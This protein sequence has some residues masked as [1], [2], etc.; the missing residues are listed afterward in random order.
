MASLQVK[1]KTENCPEWLQIEETTEGKLGSSYS[2]PVNVA[3][4]TGKYRCQ[5]ANE[6]TRTRRTM[7]ETCKA[8]LSDR[9]SGSAG[10]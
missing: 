2:F 10:T 5:R 7:S 4:W 3:P 6:S 8:C 9:Y 1:C